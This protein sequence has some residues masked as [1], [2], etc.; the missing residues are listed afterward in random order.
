MWAGYHQHTQVLHGGRSVKAFNPVAWPDAQRFIALVGREHAV[1]G[2]ANRD[3]R[4]K[5][6]DHPRDDPKRQSARMSRLLHRLHVDELV[7][8]MSRSRR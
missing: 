8:K 1:R 2:F 7:A 5:L 4:A 6:T 3:L